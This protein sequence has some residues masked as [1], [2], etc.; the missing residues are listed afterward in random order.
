MQAILRAVLS[1]GF[2]LTLVVRPDSNAYRIHADATLR[3]KAEPLVLDLAGNGFALTSIEQPVMFDMRGSGKAE[4][5]AWTAVG[6]DDAFLAIDWTRSGAIESAYELL[7]GF[8][9]PNGFAELTSLEREIDG[10]LTGQQPDG[11]ID[12]QDPIFQRLILWVDSNHDGISQSDELKSP[13]SVGLVR[14]FLGYEKV[15]RSD[16][17]GNLFRYCGRAVVNNQ[18]GVATARDLCTIRLAGEAVGIGQ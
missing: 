17:F 13:N 12:A 5:T 7:G 10:R 3:P 8:H 1:I 14:I 4:R 15:D 11:I 2:I 18:S 9:G 6:S 16:A